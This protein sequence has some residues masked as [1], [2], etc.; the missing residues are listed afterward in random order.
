MAQSLE[1]SRPLLRVEIRQEPQALACG[2]SPSLGGR[3]L[4]EVVGNTDPEKE[5]R[6]VS[7]VFAF[8]ISCSCSGFFVMVYLFYMFISLLSSSLAF[9]ITMSDYI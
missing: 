7:Y 3:R 1:K 8:G 9:P 4:Q 5:T 2:V 6:H